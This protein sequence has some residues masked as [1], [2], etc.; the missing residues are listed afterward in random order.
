MA[1]RPSLNDEQAM[2]ILAPKGERVKRRALP[3][4]RRR[5][6]PRKSLASVL[7]FLDSCFRRSCGSDDV[8]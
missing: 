7:G 4:F 5:P 2:P 6:A 8:S 1:A 3:S